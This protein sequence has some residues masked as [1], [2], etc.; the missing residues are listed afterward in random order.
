MKLIKVSAMWC[1]ACLVMNNRL[2][3][4]IDE[5]DIEVIEYD[6]D[7]DEEDVKKFDVGKILPVMIFMNDDKEIKRLVGE[8]SEKDLR[9]EISDVL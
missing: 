3:K 5:F 6:Y 2:N 8:V 1:P 9:K 4:I 7:M